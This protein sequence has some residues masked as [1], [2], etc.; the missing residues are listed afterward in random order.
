M[1]AAAPPPSAAPPRRMI[2][3]SG[4]WDWRQLVEDLHLHYASRPRK[5]GGPTR[6]QRRE[7]DRELERSPQRLRPGDETQP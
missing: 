5:P 4:E 7:K 3:W 6:P 2:L 1:S